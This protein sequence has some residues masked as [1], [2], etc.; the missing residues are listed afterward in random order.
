MK[1]P[2][3]KN[4]G[5]SLFYDSLSTP[6]PSL[7]PLQ[8]PPYFYNYNPPLPTTPGN[9]YRLPNFLTTHMYICRS[10]RFWWCHF[11]FAPPFRPCFITSFPPPPDSFHHFS[12]VCHSP[13][14]PIS[15]FSPQPTPIQ[16]NFFH[17]ILAFNFIIRI[18]V[19][20][21]IHI[22]YIVALCKERI[23][24]Y[25]VFQNAHQDLNRIYLIIQNTLYIYVCKLLFLSKMLRSVAHTYYGRT[26]NLI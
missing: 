21:Y 22:M 1:F 24:I 19:C 25:C 8:H 6:P 17:S 23:P 7:L 12:S 3:I 26:D 4:T 10:I 16:N 15:Q 18:Y 5:F 13:S 9:P 20:I 2:W 11:H 14:H